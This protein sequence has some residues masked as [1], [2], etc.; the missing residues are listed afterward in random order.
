MRMLLR[1]LSRL[2]SSCIKNTRALIW[3]EVSAGSPRAFG[4]KPKRRLLS[5][6]RKYPMSI[7]SPS[8]FIAYL[9]RGATARGICK[10]RSQTLIGLLGPDGFRLLDGLKSAK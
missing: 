9:E 6:D 10:A 7:D 2:L 5:S 3:V 1:Y 8:H 4:H